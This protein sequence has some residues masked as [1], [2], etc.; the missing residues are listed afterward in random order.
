M[1]TATAHSAPGAELVGTTLWDCKIVGLGKPDAQRHSTLRVICKCRG[2]RPANTA[3]TFTV[4]RENFL[5][6]RTRSCGCDRRLAAL[7]IKGSQKAQ[8]RR[9]QD[10]SVATARVTAIP[11]H[12]ITVE[13]QTP[14]DNFGPTIPKCRHSVYMIPTDVEAGLGLARYCTLCTPV[15]GNGRK[16]NQKLWEQM[17]KDENL[18]V[19]RGMSLNGKNFIT[20]YVAPG[21][22]EHGD[23]END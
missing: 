1:S 18:S 16:P 21:E 15:T 17:L 4:R 9:N 13:T 19:H 6:G 2:K 11:E 20:N 12:S 23:N 5:S 22:G 8:S 10:L 7:G 14:A 3:P